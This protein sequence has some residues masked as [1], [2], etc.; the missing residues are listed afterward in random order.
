MLDETLGAGFLQVPLHIRN[1]PARLMK[2]I[3]YGSGYKHEHDFPEGCPPQEYLP[4]AVSGQIFYM[5]A[6]A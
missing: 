1:A 2:D 5:P 3:G 4:E 6:N